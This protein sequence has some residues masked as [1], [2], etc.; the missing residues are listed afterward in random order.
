MI[1]ALGVAP[2]AS[3]DT[4]TIGAAASPGTTFGGAANFAVFQVETD[5]ASPSFVV[6]PVPAGAAPWSVTS[7]GALGG[8]GDGS[9]AIEIWRPTGTPDEFRLIAIGPQQPFPTGVLTTHSVDIPVLP[10]DHL[11]VVSGPDTDFSANYGSGLSGDL[12]IWQV[13]PTTPAVGQTMGAPSSD[14]SPHGGGFDDR[15]NVQATLT[16][17]RAVTTPAKTKCKKKKHKKK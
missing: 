10:G 14:F 16:A 8:D 6:P 3:A 1:A 2:G 4:A 11:G 15:A 9:A 5:P 13:G 12:A 7:W 17:T